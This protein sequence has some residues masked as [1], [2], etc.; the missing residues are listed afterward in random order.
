MNV[1]SV[2]RKFWLKNNDKIEFV[3][4]VTAVAVGTFVL[5]KSAEKINDVTTEVKQR[6]DF[7]KE[8]D[9]EQNGWE[10]AGEDRGR[11]IRETVKI[12]TVGYVKSAGLGVGLIAGGEVLQGISHATLTNKLGTVAASLAGV[13]T[14]FAKYRER[15]VEDQ[16]QDKDYQY[17]T[18]GT[19][20]VVEMK[21]D[22]T[23]VKTSIPVHKDT[24]NVYIPHSFF[25]DESNINW[26]D[27]PQANYD[28]LCSCETQI[29]NMLSMRDFLTEND[30]RFVPGA[31][32][33]KAGAAAGAKYLNKDKT[34]NYISFGM[35]KNTEQ[36]KAFRNGTETNFLVEI[37]YTDAADPAMRTKWWPISDNILNDTDWELC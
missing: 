1:L 9:K 14:S 27:V 24:T 30:I 6:N 29:N 19:M 12:A 8:V 10:E 25:F 26:T 2:A 35:E 28:F 5:I 23:V 18:G 22:G 34:K 11:Y 17:L 36:A 13:S 32:R 4:G 3:A 31:P 33:T 16:G 7:V 37:M 15:V 21:K 20:E